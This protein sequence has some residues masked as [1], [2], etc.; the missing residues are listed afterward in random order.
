MFNRKN[1]FYEYS[2]ARELPDDWD[3]NLTGNIYLKRQFLG[4]ME[5][6]S[7]N[8]KARYCALRNKSG[9]L[10]S[11]FVLFARPDYIFTQFTDKV[12][13]LK[14]FFIY[15]PLS[16]ARPGIALS[17]EGMEQTFDF[18]RSLRGM[19]LVMNLPETLTSRGFSQVR[20]CP[21]CVLELR[22]ECFA[23]YLA[24][25]RSSYRNRYKKALRR[26]EEL[27]LYQLESN[28]DFS[29][30]LYHLYEQ[31]HE[32]ALYKIEKLQLDFFRGEFFKIFVL[33]SPAGKPVA[34]F[35]LLENGPELI[36]EFAGMDY[37][38]A[39]QYDAYIRMLLEIVRYGI[40]NGFKRIEFGQTAED[41]KL[42]LGCRYE[43]LFVLARHSNPFLNL[44][45]KICKTWLQY[46]PLPE[47]AYH[48]FTNLK[49]E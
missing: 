13:R 26:S 33:E 40:E 4:L 36:F 42:K 27:R 46:K 21:C 32:K 19:S 48:V 25:L 16:V 28:R 22:W 15:V 38:A 24:S 49:F 2:D 34:F 10:V 6:A 47:S 5:G 35:Q 12:L 23:E 44:L 3:E 8:G 39:P 18:I 43:N 45:L 9:Q 11:R 20:T 31:V 41:A 14:T 7:D 17:A 1:N 29:E 30:E 37:A